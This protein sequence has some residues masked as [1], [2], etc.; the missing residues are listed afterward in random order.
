MPPR[1]GNFKNLIYVCAMISLNRL[2]VSF[3]VSAEDRGRVSHHFAA[4]QAQSETRFRAT[5]V[6][7]SPVSARKFAII[8]TS[9][10]AQS[11]V[12]AIIRLFS[13]VGEGLTLAQTIA[14]HFLFN[15]IIIIGK[16]FALKRVYMPFLRSQ[17][18]C[19]GSP[20]G[21]KLT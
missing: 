3:V 20:F 11:K 8:R 6:D 14:R 4:P 15:I 12:N 2:F 7:F 21:I 9:D 16:L 17:F 13:R 10:A 18:F 1:F 5:G 19:S